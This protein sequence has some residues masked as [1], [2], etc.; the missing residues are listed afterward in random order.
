MSLRGWSRPAREGQGPG[1]RFLLGFAIGL[2]SSG[3]KGA[4][5]IIQRTCRS[6]RKLVGGGLGGEAYALSEMVDIASLWREFS[7]PLVDMSSGAIG[8]EDRGSLFEH[9]HNQKSVAE[10]YRVRHFLGIQLT[11]GNREFGI[12]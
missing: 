1:G 9:L 3:L 4:R 10:G 6:S 5:H 12:A 2:S 8:S 11:S 7:E